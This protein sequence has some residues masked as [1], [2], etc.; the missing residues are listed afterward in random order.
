MMSIDDFLDRVDW[1]KM[2][3]S[4]SAVLAL[5]VI[6]VLGINLLFSGTPKVSLKKTEFEYGQKVEISSQ[7]TA[8]EGEKV[9]ST[10]IKSPTELDLETKT[11]SFNEMDTSKL[12][13]QKI[14][15]D[16]T[17]KVTGKKQKPV[18][19]T[20]KIIDSVGPEID[21]KNGLEYE[22]EDFL[23]L[24]ALDLAEVK[25]QCSSTDDIRLA[26]TFDG[27]AEKG[28]S[29]NGKIT[30]TDL[31]GNS[32]VK[33]F[34]IR[35][36]EDPKPEP[37]LPKDESVS[38][39]VP[40]E[41]DKNTIADSKPSTDEITTTPPS[42]SYSIPESPAPALEIQQ[43]APQPVKPA[44]RYFMFTDGYDMGNVEAACSAAGNASGFSYACTP[45]SDGD[46]IYTGMALI[47]D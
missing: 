28:K 34:Q 42:P 32:T 12:G 2:I 33:E 10:M 43:P 20:V 19:V 37:V 22:L 36:K 35:I 8:I 6:A 3:I 38:P 41:Y 16:I 44:N 11:V 9:Y 47:F 40:L 4:G 25:D 18:V 14:I 24:S 13:P 31:S 7:I 5:F 23:N 1:K 45:I 30:A 26:M 29:L 39:Q 21:L 27:K 17:D 15:F 46:G